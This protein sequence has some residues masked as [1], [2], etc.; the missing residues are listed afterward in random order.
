MK[1]DGGVEALPSRDK[2]AANQLFD[3]LAEYGVFVVRA[4]EIEDW[5]KPLSVPGKKTEWT[6]AML[7]RLGS[8]PSDPAYVQPASGDVWDFMRSIVRWIKNP[9]RKGTS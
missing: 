4:G 1:N 5:L 2:Q 6:I 8:D 3:T 9:D 7:E